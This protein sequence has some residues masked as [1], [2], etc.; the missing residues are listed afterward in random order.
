LTAPPDDSPELTTAAAG[1]RTKRVIFA[2][3]AVV[4]LSLG[5][6]GVF[7]PGIPT[8]PFLLLACY[9]SAKSS[10]RI[11]HYIQ[12]S[13][14]FGPMVRDWQEHRGIRTRTKVHALGFVAI[15]VTI[16]VLSTLSYPVVMVSGL[17]L[18]LIGIL[19]ILRLPTI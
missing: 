9:F 17:L 8:T 4:T 19:V 3:L 11:Y 14:L 6:I 12:Q 10:P 7:M 15:G 1:S 18:A 13:A 2:T 16:L 5:A